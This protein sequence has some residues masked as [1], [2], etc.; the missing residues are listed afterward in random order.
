MS[1]RFR[2]KPLNAVQDRPARMPA[3]Q[4]L[5]ALLPRPGKR[6]LVGADLH[7]ESTET[8][9]GPVSGKPHI[10]NGMPHL[11]CVGVVFGTH[12]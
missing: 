4:L 2:S 5:P 3:P 9:H 6:L 1:A 8:W 10:S 7:V 12:R 11:T